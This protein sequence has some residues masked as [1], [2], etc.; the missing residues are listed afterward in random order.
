MKAKWYK[1]KDKTEV[2]KMGKW[3][4]LEIFKRP[5]GFYCCFVWNKGEVIATNGY[6]A[7]ALPKKY[8]AIR[9]GCKK[10]I[11]LGIENNPVQ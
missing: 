11:E 7:S 2:L 3:K 1:R 4:V 5:G 9:W 10:I 8:H 6:H